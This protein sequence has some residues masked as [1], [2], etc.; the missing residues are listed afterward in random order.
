[1][2]WWKN[3][4]L[5]WSIYAGEQIYARGRKHKCPNIFVYKLKFENLQKVFKTL[6]LEYPKTAVC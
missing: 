4:P 5:D 1:M 2:I 3:F 6:F